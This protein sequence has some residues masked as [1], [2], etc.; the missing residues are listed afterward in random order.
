MIDWKKLGLKLAETALHEIGEWIKEARGAGPPAL[1][2]GEAHICFRCGRS[3][4]GLT[5]YPKYSAGSELRD[6]AHGPE[7]LH[8]TKR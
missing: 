6:F 5:L 1:T 8:C 2:V 4:T 7:P 3:D